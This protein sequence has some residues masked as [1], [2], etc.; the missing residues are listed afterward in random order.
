MFVAKAVIKYI[1]LI[2]T[3]KRLDDKTSFIEMKSIITHI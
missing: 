1:I 2:F 3:I